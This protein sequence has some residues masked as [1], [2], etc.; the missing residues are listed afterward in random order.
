MSIRLGA[1]LVDVVSEMS[2]PEGP[3]HEL[4]V[5]LPEDAVTR[6]LDWFA[7]HYY[8]PASSFMISSIHTWVVRLAGKIILID[9]CV[10][11]DKPR[12]AFE[13]IHELSLPYLERL[14][15]VGVEPGDVDYVMCTHLHLDHVGWNTRLVGDRWVP[16]FPHAEYIF[17]R[18]DYAHW[19]PD[20]GAGRDDPINE[21]VFADSVA[22]IAAS[23]QMRLVDSGYSP[24]DGL[25]LV[26]APGHTPGHSVVRLTSEGQS[27]VFFGDLMHS[28]L[29][30]AYPQVNSIFCLD[31]ARAATTRREILERAARDGDLL[32]SAHFPSPHSGRVSAD[33][34]A[35]R[36]HPRT[37]D[38]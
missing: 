38:E 26:S 14:A 7:P 3:P 27:G 36:F 13:F 8:D 21:N 30:V 4:L 10:G 25:T 35:F 16:T 29:Q 18:D 2:F 15:E 19:E 5:G 22:P 20:T 24:V 34:D 17:S 6:Q 1:A 37:P 9:T 32:F 31:Q 28:P 11:N 12:P 23:G 33:G